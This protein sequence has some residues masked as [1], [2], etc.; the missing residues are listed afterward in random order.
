MA[1][2]DKGA[3]Q[4]I[5]LVPQILIGRYDSCTFSSLD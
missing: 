3:K 1:N 5:S 2:F 4:T